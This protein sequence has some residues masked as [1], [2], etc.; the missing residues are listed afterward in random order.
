M[1]V[2][3]TRNSETIQNG[4]FGQYYNFTVTTDNGLVSPVTFEVSGNYYNAPSAEGGSSA[5]CGTS[6]K[7]NTSGSNLRFLYQKRSACTINQTYPGGPF[8][9]NLEDFYCRLK[10]GSSVFYC[11]HSGTETIDGVTVEIKNSGNAS[12][13]GDRSN[14]WGN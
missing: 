9:F 13:I 4:N 12:D 1:I 14:I 7:L 10:I 11:N 2:T 8:D 6:Q 3:V 5:S